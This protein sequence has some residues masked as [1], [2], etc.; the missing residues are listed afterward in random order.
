MK[1]DLAY[2]EKHKEHLQKHFL[3]WEEFVWAE[4][5]NKKE[6]IFPALEPFVF[7]LGC[8]PFLLVGWFLFWPFLF[9]ALIPLLV[10]YIHGKRIA[11]G[12]L[13]PH[14]LILTNRAIYYCCGKDCQIVYQWSFSEIHGIFPYQTFKGKKAVTILPNQ[15]AVSLFAPSQKTGLLTFLKNQ[16]RIAGG[17]PIARRIYSLSAYHGSI[18]NRNRGFTDFIELCFDE[19]TEI[20]AP[21]EG[22]LH[23]YPEIIYKRR[24]RIMSEDDWQRIAKE[25][26][27]IKQEWNLFKNDGKE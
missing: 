23:A 3:D 11:Q 8:V 26:L 18:R 12:A 20:F 25:P 4:K 21:L 14:W 19:G 7:N 6:L 1:N 15:S 9:T 5:I 24:L 2:W 13:L 10:F 27:A 17:K 16:I 22:I